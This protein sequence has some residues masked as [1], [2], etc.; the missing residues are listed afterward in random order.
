MPPSP[1]IGVLSAVFPRLL[2]L[3]II[4]GSHKRMRLS[5][6]VRRLAHFL[7]CRVVRW[8]RSDVPP[9]QVPVLAERGGTQLRAPRGVVLID[10]REQNPFD[11]SRFTGWFSGVEKKALPLGDYS[12]AGLENVCVVE[13]KDLECCYSIPRC[14]SLAKTANSR[15]LETP[16][17]P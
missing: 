16:S 13:R 4:G 5:F 10:T 8:L 2:L 15:R 7:R 1:D 12:V 14:C 6:L 11:F 9:P 3:G 17:F